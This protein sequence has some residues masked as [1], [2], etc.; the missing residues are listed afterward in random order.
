MDTTPSPIERSRFSAAG[1][2]GV[3]CF[4]AGGAILTVGALWLTSY[5]EARQFRMAR[6]LMMLLLL[7]VPGLLYSRLHPAWRERSPSIETS[8]AVGIA[9]GLAVL[10]GFLTGLGVTVARVGTSGLT[11]R[12]LTTFLLFTTLFAAL[13]TWFATALF[14]KHVIARANPDR[15]TTLREFLDRVRTGPAP[16]KELLGTESDWMPLGQLDVGG[17]RLQITDLEHIGD[18]RGG[19]VIPVPQGLYLVEARVVT[20]AREPRISR[21]RVRVDLVPSTLGE[22]AGTV[23][24]DVGAVVVC[25]VDRLATWRAANEDA[26]RQWVAC[27]ANEPLNGAG[28]YPCEPAGT[29]VFYVA[30]GFG[31]GTFPAFYLMTKG[32][33]PVG[34]EV[35]FIRAGTPYPFERGTE[36]VTPPPPPRS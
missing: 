2:L 31:G 4:V 26:W 11:T 24:V 29:S 21:L 32:G 30:S 6:Q 22:R 9:T 36:E 17:S 3:V 7:L 10:I 23:H 12:G 19:T 25:D 34:L 14:A 13:A 16:T 8:S 35:E 28:E 20:Y 33:H 27:L 1:L 5:L 18:E 15:E